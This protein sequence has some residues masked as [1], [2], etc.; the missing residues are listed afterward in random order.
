MNESGRSPSPKLRFAVLERD[1]FSCFYCGARRPSAVLVIDHFI[2]WSQGGRTE[3]Y[4]LVAACVECNIGKSDTVPFDRQA[5]YRHVRARGNE[6]SEAMLRMNPAIMAKWPEHQLPMMADCLADPFDPEQRD[7][8]AKEVH[9][10]F[11][12]TDAEK[13]ALLAAEE[14]Q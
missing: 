12:T 13:A 7:G 9:D 14:E 3:Y 1:G 4:N 6:R 11:L 10:R 2:P 5:I 8:W